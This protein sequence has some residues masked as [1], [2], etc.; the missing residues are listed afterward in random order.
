MAFFVR[1]HPG[2]V[3]DAILCF[4]AAGQ[5]SYLPRRGDRSSPANTP[6]RRRTSPP[7]KDSSGAGVNTAD[8]TTLE[9][10][11]RRGRVM[12]H[13]KPFFKTSHVPCGPFRRSRGPLER[14]K[15]TWPGSRGRRTIAAR[16]PRDASD[17]LRDRRFEA[18]A[19]S[20]RTRSIRGATFRK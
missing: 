13:G 7:E 9:S 3:S 18:E 14:V 6:T 4:D 2:R 11:N 19:I 17:L 5:V 20:N 8:K 12:H 15:T 10:L 1:P 16:S